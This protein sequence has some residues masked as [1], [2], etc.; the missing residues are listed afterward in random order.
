M[1]ECLSLCS[2]NLFFFFHYF[3]SRHS[4]IHSLLYLD[5]HHTQA[6]IKET[7]GGRETH[8]GGGRETQEDGGRETQEDGGR[9]TQE[10]GGRETQE[11]GERRRDAM[12]QIHRY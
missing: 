3:I 10:G 8:E 12:R 6:G 9:E 5:L 2:R 1:Q 4:I 7:D 11:D